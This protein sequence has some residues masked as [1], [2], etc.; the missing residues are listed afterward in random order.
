MKTRTI[1]NQYGSVVI[2]DDVKEAEKVL[3]ELKEKTA[4]DA[5]IARK[6]GHHNGKKATFVPEE[7][8]PGRKANRAARRAERRASKKT[9]KRVANA[10]KLH[11]KS[12]EEEIKICAADASEIPSIYQ[13]DVPAGLGIC[14]DLQRQFCVQ[15]YGNE[16]DALFLV[17]GTKITYWKRYSGEEPEVFDER[18]WANKARMSEL[19]DTPDF[20]YLD[21]G[22]HEWNEL[23]CYMHEDLDM[24]TKYNKRD[25]FL[26]AVC[27][28]TIDG[29]EIKMLFY[30]ETLH[31][32]AKLKHDLPAK[33]QINHNFSYTVTDEKTVRWLMLNTKS[34]S[35]NCSYD[36]D[37]FGNYV[38]QIA[39]Y[40]D[41]KEGLTLSSCPKQEKTNPEENYQFR[42][43][44]YEEKFA[45]FTEPITVNHGLWAYNKDFSCTEIGMRECCEQFFNMP[46]GA[47]FCASEHSQYVG[48]FGVQIHNPYVK[49]AFEEDAFSYRI[50]V[51]R[52]CDEKFYFHKAVTTKKMYNFVV[53]KNKKDHRYMELFVRMTDDSRITHFWI[54]EEF[55]KEHPD[56][57]GHIEKIA[58][59]RGYKTIV[60]KG[61]K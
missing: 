11:E 41:L 8:V 56:L 25:F 20:V 16:Q 55:Q 30:S 14:S 34:V 5:A 48:G 21:D 49:A 22:L 12:V 4:V 50:G 1:S 43:L 52:Y 18:V 15:L 31:A 9:A 10:L 29:N 59:E 6:A 58:A 2:I 36:Y 60:V 13:K 40:A 26:D 44:M 39:Y 17:P 51:K 33:I 61:D 38:G 53:R 7:K 27:F 3:A 24:V 54:K 37:E 35:A 23:S 42:D 19:N 47:E 46:E 28:T 32:V 57:A 45:N